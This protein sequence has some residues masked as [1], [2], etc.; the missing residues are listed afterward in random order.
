[1]R[2]GAA[3]PAAVLGKGKLR[4]RRAAQLPLSVQPSGLHL[5]GAPCLW[6]EALVEA[7]L[8]GFPPG[9]FWF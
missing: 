2:L 5:P 8:A 9:N 4:G 6:L 1:M 3:A 7:L